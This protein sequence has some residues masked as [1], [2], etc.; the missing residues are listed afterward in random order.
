[1]PK[2]PTKAEQK[3]AIDYLRS[4]GKCASKSIDNY[5]C[6]QTANHQGRNH[7][8]QVMGGAEDGKTLKEWEW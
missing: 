5:L 2:P 6:T 8:A 7:K 4:K 1:M 3:A